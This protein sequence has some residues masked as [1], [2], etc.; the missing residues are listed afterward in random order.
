MPGKANLAEHEIKLTS[1]KPVRSKPYPTPHNL[2]K[3]INKEIDTMLGI[4]II[5]R[6]DSA[7][8]APLVKKA[9]GSNCIC[10]NH[11][12]LNK[13]TIFYPDP[14]MSKEDFFN[15]LLGSQV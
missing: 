1:D 13:L 15:K 10:Y 8:V 5:E 2:Q 4:G 12:Q 3:E 11:K 6:S 14:M 7:Y 9:D